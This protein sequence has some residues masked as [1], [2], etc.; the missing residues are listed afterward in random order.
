M[1]LYQL[2][3]CKLQ[4]LYFGKAMKQLKIKRNKAN[5]TYL[6]ISHL[7]LELASNSQQYHISNINI[8][9]K[10]VSSSCFLKDFMLNTVYLN[11]KMTLKRLTKS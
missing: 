4:N 10:L 6:A 7:H 2:I 11:T 1:Y 9:R 5:T 3:I 8:N